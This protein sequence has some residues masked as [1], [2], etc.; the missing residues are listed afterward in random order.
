MAIKIRMMCPFCFIP[1]LA[2]FSYNDPSIDVSP[3]C[4]AFLGE[5]KVELVMIE[6]Y[7]KPA[8]G[9]LARVRS[10]R[11]SLTHTGRWKSEDSPIW[12][13]PR[14]AKRP[15]WW[16]NCRYAPAWP[17]Q[18][19]IVHSKTFS[20]D[21]FII[22]TQLTMFSS[23]ASAGSSAWLGAS[24]GAAW[25]LLAWIAPISLTGKFI[26]LWVAED[27]RNNSHAWVWTHGFLIHCKRIVPL[28]FTQLS[29]KLWPGYL[30][31]PHF[32]LLSPFPLFLSI[33]LSLSG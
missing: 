16:L 27:V 28:W 7:E 17:L 8:D 24:Q 15:A 23:F 29:I 9:M 21:Y 10:D 31:L 26:L 6:T 14:V 5:V 11:I 33:S 12:S 13:C 32:S 30:H 18:L 25:A 19:F 1:V 20:L 2:R 3:I 4:Q 22:M